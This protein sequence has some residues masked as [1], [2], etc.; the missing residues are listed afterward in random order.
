[1][2]LSLA[3]QWEQVPRCRPLRRDSILDPDQATQPLY[4]LCNGSLCPLTLS[5][6]NPSFH[7][8]FLISVMY[9]VSVMS[10]MP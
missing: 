8:L 7:K 3:G 2:G 6:T 9:F 1:M 4:L 10:H 5:Q